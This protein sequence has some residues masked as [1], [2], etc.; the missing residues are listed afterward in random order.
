[1][2]SFLSDLGVTLRFSITE[3]DAIISVRQFIDDP[4]LMMELNRVAHLATAMFIC[5]TQNDM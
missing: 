5:S 1:M 3:I 4:E 2:T